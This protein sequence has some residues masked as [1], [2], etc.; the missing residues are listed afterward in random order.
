MHTYTPPLYKKVP[1]LLQALKF[2]KKIRKSE[3]AQTLE[4]F[5]SGHENEHHTTDIRRV[6]IWIS[7]FGVLAHGPMLRT[8]SGRSASCRFGSS[9]FLLD[10]IRLGMR[11]ISDQMTFKLVIKSDQHRGL[12][13]KI[14][15]W[16]YKLERQNRKKTKINFLPFRR[17]Y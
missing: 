2:L 7:Y 8:S 5:L 10:Q 14:C 12:R 13:A 16:K 9:S 15:A 1:K 3:S 11:N 17:I 4:S 6:S